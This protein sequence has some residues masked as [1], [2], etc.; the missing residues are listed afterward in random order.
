[1]PVILGID[2]DAM[3][4]ELPLSQTI[5]QALTLRQGRLGRLLTDIEASEQGST[6]SDV[7]A[8]LMLQAA[9]EA[10]ALMDTHIS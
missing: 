10:R 4:Q 1:M 3:L 5:H 2:L 8:E 7:P 9:A 6:S